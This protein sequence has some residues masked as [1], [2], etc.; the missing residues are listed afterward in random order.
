MRRR[1]SLAGN[2]PG[3]FAMP[4]VDRAAELDQHD[5]PA[6]AAELIVARKFADLADGDVLLE[7]FCGPGAFLDAARA[8]H[9]GVRAVGIEIDPLRASDARAKGHE[10]IIG[11]IRHVAIPI[12]RVDAIVT[13]PPFDLTLV[14]VLI[15]KAKRI[16]KPSGRMGM[17]IAAYAIQTED[18]VLRYND[19]FSLDV[20]SV[21]RRLFP[22]LI[23]PLVYLTFTKDRRRVMNGFFLYPELTDVRGLPDRYA[24]VLQQP[25]SGS[26]WFDVV[27]RALTEHGGTARLDDLYRTIEGRRPTR[28]A[29]WRQQIRKV[30]Q[31]RCERV[32]PETYR[33]PQAA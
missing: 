23:S 20:A 21:P 6:W 1:A 26:L 5:T 9:P 8:I 27:A 2:D 24:H 17:L 12:D 4:D 19:D 10:V 7:P 22:G 28:T 11:D 13:N 30:V 3:L 31:H 29:F 15:D 33:L 14:D 32:A 18:R 16:L 25:S